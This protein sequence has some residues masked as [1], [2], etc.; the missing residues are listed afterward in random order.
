MNI[1]KFARKTGELVN[2]PE[3]QSGVKLAFVPAPLPPKWDFPPDL[4]SLLVEARVTM[5]LLNGIGQTLPN[6]ELLL[7]PLQ[8]REAL[9]ASSL[10]GTY[11]SPEQLLLFQM[12]PTEPTSEQD[13]ANSVLEVANYSTALREG[14]RLLENLPFC[15]RLIQELHRVLLRGVRGRDRTPGEFRKS[16]VY[17][18]SDKRY[19]PP[20]SSRL[21]ECL[22]AFEKELNKDSGDYDPLVRCYLAHYQFEAIHPFTDGN[23]R[24]GRALLA[25]MT[26]KWCDLSM[27]WLYMSAF[28]EKYKDEYFGNLFRVSADGAWKQWVEFCLR[29]TIVQA[30]DSIRRCKALNA[31]KEKFHDIGDASSLRAPQ[32]IDSLFTTPVLTIS[33]TAKKYAI[34][35]ATAKTDVQRLVGKKI[36]AQIENI[37][38]KMYYSPE[39]L[40]ISYEEPAFD[41]E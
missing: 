6:P 29:G 17:I 25:L 8:S 22:D 33:G 38:P 21:N 2:I 36:L 7:R 9:R 28:F 18:G 40:N 37:R 32:I 3:N 4:V 10:E 23:G 14:M 16:Q 1:S 27:P 12:H 34:T 41:E 35:Y 31:A 5:S 24:V 39:I 20:P 26:Y 30:K 19:V 11:A 13:Q 15:L